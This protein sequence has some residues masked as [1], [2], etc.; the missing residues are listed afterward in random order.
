[1]EKS[2]H[3][4]SKVDFEMVE[5]ARDYHDDGHSL[6]GIQGLMYKVHGYHLSLDTIRDWVYFRTRSAR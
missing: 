2:K 1:M 6:Q 5:K 4:K 3:H